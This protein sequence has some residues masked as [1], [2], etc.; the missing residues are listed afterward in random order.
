MMRLTSAKRLLILHIPTKRDTGPPHPERG[1]RRIHSRS[2]ST[3]RPAWAA[4]VKSDPSVVVGD[5]AGVGL[6]NT[7]RMRRGSPD[8]KL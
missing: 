5:G 2:S 3:L 8:E 7:I 1:S 6:M 4:K